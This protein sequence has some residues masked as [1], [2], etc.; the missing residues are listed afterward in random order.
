M[1]ITSALFTGVTGLKANSEAMNVIGNNIA[2]V[3]TTGF[4]GGRTV[5]SDLISAN[6]VGSNSQVGLGVQ[7]LTWR[8][9]VILS[10]S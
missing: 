4:K 9:R 1:G 3:N 6:A 5:F 8:F 2:N 10:S 7:V